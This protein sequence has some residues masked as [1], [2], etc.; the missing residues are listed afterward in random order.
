MLT[1]AEKSVLD[2][3]RQYLM[4]QGEMLCFH[5]PL[6]DKHHT[7]LR[8]LTERDLLFQE[9]FKGGYSLTETGFAAMKSEMLA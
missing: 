3:F 9:S 2:V 8:Q 5:G 6:W 7:S 1:A 4:D